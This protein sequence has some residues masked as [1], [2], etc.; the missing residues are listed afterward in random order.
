MSATNLALFGL[1]LLCSGIV[2][3]RLCLRP[4]P[5]VQTADDDDEAGGDKDD[6]DEEED[7]DTI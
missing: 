1:A 6:D 4:P 7:L 3:S 5:P 2:L